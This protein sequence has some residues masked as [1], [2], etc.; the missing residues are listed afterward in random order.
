M[1]NK[2]ILDELKTSA[3]N[4]GS[5]LILTIV[6]LVAVTIVVKLLQQLVIRIIDRGDALKG[7]NVDPLKSKTL[8]SLFTSVIAYTLYLFA[9]AYIITLYFGPIGFT[10]AG[11]GG[12]AIGL[13][14]QS[15]IK[16]ILSGLFIIIEDKYKIGEFITV[17]TKSGFVEEIG[18]RTTILRDFNGDMHIIPNGNIEEVTNVSRGDRRFLVD[19]T[20]SPG[21]S[22][23]RAIEILNHVAEEFK[24]THSELI[25][26]P[27]VVGVVNIRDIGATLRTQGK[28]EYRNH[29][30]YENDLRRD[31]LKAFQDEGIKTGINIYP[32]GGIVR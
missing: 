23:E 29:W 30:Q 28:A 16:D 32:E 4:G 22:V 3:L 17:G 19:V 26:G 11:V 15:F 24:K 25:I 1:D 20:I 14:A 18:M 7:K 8:K 6:V 12:V 27:D 5:N 9:I 2:K 21:Q 10:L 13:G 31:I